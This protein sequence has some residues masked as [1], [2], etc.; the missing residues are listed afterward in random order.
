M[1]VAIEDRRPRSAADPGRGD[2]GLVEESRNRRPNR[3]SARDL[4]TTAVVAGGFVAAAVAL[5]ATLP[6]QPAPS[7]ALVI[8]LVAAYALLSRI[9]LEVGTGSAV[10]TQ[11]VFVPMLFVLPVSLVPFCVAAGYVLGGLPDYLGRRM[12]PTRLLV[13]I[14]GSWFA[15]GP[16]VVLG[17]FGS[18]TPT[19]RDAPLYAAA[20]AAQF[21][22]DFASS[23]LRERIVF[24]HAIRALLP[25]FAWVYA[26]DSFLAPVGLGAA[27]SG[28]AAFLVVLPLAAL[29]AL[30]ARDRRARID[31]IVAVGQAYRG[32]RDE[33]RKGVV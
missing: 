15:I 31:R 8:V 7:L 10:P 30:L 33:D 5:A 6:S 16:V 21:G 18:G 27:V 13:L 29:L 17:F 22:L 24:G 25:S 20:L 11:V 32:A 9:E 3:P 26:V 2:E 23:S 19:W 28:T 1:S 4:R 14:A 12:H